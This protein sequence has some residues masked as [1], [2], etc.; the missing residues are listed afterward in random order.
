MKRRSDNTTSK[1]HQ[2]Y[3][4]NYIVDPN[5]SL[6]LFKKRWYTFGNVAD[7]I[8]PPTYN[9]SIIAFVNDR[10]PG[11]FS[12][13]KALTPLMV[14]DFINKRL[15]VTPADKRVMSKYKDELNRT[16]DPVLT[17]IHDFF[18]WMNLSQELTLLR[19]KNCRTRFADSWPPA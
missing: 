5:Y 1:K 15:P 14:F 13:I 12:D 17:N 18:C 3:I 16:P 6:T 9:K 11:D 7:L 8:C 19:L 10:L 2:T 4:S